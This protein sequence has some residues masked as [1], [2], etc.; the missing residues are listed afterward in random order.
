MR[1]KSA[2]ALAAGGLLLVALESGCEV[3][4]GKMYWAGQSPGYQL[5]KTCAPAD[6]DSKPSVRVEVTDDK[7]KIPLRGASVRLGRKVGAR[8]AF[9]TGEAGYA[10]VG[11]G[12]GTWEVDVTLRG[13]RSAHY[14]LELPEGQACTL[15]FRLSI[16]PDQGLGF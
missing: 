12:P 13:Y 5:E 1:P 3:Y 10:E 16:D 7:E 15:A 6:V 8:F 2:L 11:V 14:V 9:V 4:H